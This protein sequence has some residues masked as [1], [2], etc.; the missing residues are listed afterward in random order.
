M[1]VM[2]SSID[3]VRFATPSPLRVDVRLTDEAP[4]G[5]QSESSELLAFLT[6]SS[7]YF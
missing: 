3:L 2:V 5:T 1:I 4:F 7:Q 6:I